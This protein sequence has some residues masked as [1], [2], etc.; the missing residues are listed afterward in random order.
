MG[1]AALHTD[2]LVL[3]VS[4]EAGQILRAEPLMRL[5]NPHDRLR[6][7]HR[8]YQLRDWNV[9]PLLY[10][11]WSFAASK[12]GRRVVVAVR[13]LAQ[14]VESPCF[15]DELLPTSFSRM[16]SA[17]LTAFAAHLPQG[18][19]AIPGDLISGNGR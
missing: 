5:G 9:G 17:K 10:G 15:P 4:D 1:I 7:A 18:A 19:A 8:S 2:G 16:G 6:R 3:I 11:N 13:R 14:K 12:R